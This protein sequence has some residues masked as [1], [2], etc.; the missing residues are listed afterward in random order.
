MA[1]LK[2]VIVTQARV[3]STR[4]PEKVLKDVGG[5]NTMLSLHLKRLKRSKLFDDIIVA[6]THEEKVNK[7]ESIAKNEN[8]ISFRGSTNDVLD[9]FYQAA[10]NHHPDYIVRVTSDCP[11]IDADLVDQVILLATS[12]SLDYVSN[13]LSEEYP[14]GQDIEVIKWQVLERAWKEAQIPSEREH[15]TPF[16]RKNLDYNGG[17]LFKGENLSAPDNFTNIRMTVDEPD[18]LKAIQTLINQLG[19]NKSWLDYT[20]YILSNPEQFNNQKNIRN[21]GYLK[22]LSKE[23]NN[24]NGSR[25]GSL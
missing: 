12:K 25:S 14:D 22:S 20:N 16:I 5:G 17:N 15:V 3:G 7:I 6:T 8:V 24:S 1:N 19:M 18:D 9:R 4:F 13:T 2:I 21:E 11:L 23:K 10:K